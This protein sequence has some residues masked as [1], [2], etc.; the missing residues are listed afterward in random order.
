LARSEPGTVAAVR[1]QV[2]TRRVPHWERHWPFGGPPLSTTTSVSPDSP[3]A[4]GGGGGQIR[5]EQTHRSARA[6]AR[7]VAATRVRGRRHCDDPGGTGPTVGQVRR[8]REAVYAC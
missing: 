8:N 3:G 1:A 5:R 6:G 4:G 2:S 7:T